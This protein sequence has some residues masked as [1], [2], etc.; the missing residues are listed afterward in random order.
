MYQIWD[1]VDVPRM[2][3]KWIE[4]WTHKHPGWQHW[5]WTLHDIRRLITRHYPDYLTLYDSYE[6]S[7]FRADA[8]RYFILHRYGGVYVDLDMDAV[9][10]M[11]AWTWYS[12]CLVSEE[13]Y[14]H[15][16]VVREQKATNVMNGFIAA[17]PNHP[18][19]DFVV[20]S[21]DDAARNYFGDYLYATG[22]GFFDAA[23]RRYITRPS[24]TEAGR[25]TVLPPFYFLPTYDPSE[26]DVISGK[27]FPTRM[28][29][30]PDKAQIVC[31]T[32]AKRSF[33][34]DVDPMAYA[35]HHWIHAYM[36]DDAWKKS[37][38]HNVFHVVPG[39]KSAVAATSNFDSV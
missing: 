22:P 1:T 19:L 26:S 28:R 38:A 10:P 17:A 4:T 34:N 23:L 18:F 9:R 7:V 36:F 3:V 14:E 27:C 11:D 32:L 35:N 24:T 21:L 16:F 30:L 5:F 39:L 25:V 20:K 15:V 29:S 6:S 37:D 33:H 8:G 31:R 12:P 13:N 2:Y